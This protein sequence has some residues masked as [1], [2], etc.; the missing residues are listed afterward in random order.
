MMFL[1]Q[2]CLLAVN[3][4]RPGE[5]LIRLVALCLCGAVYFIVLGLIF[6]G[7]EK[8]QQKGTPVV[9]A[10]TLSF[11]Q[12][13][14]QAQSAPEPEPEPE[15]ELEQEILPEP[16]EAD[17]ALETVEEKPEPQSEPEPLPE[18]EAPVAQITQQAAAPTL[19]VDSA[20][21]QDWVIKQIE[22]EKYYPAAAER[23]GLQGKFDLAVTVDE[24][25]TILSADVL[26]GRGHRI[27]RQALEKMLRKLPGQSFGQPIG[28]AVEFEVEFSFE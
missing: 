24:T 26:E 28:E 18:S 5:R 10:I 2:P 22:R 14:L 27:L 6:Q 9:R 23:L 3:R 15:P 20:N 16:E 13:E 25:G 7:L 19:L 17:V 11:V 8:Q 12:I 1:S 21:V 4:A